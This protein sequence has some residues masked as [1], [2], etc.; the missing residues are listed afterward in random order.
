MSD[1]KKKWPK[2]GNEIPFHNQYESSD[3][4]GE[5]SESEKLLEMD[6][7]QHLSCYSEY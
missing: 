2:S 5:F 7:A 4:I 6:L 1:K 3:F